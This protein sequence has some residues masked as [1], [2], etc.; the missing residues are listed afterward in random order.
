MSTRLINSDS[1][2][3]VDTQLQNMQDQVTE[4]VYSDAG[5]HDF[6]GE[7]GATITAA[8]TRLSIENIVTIQALNNLPNT[9]IINNYT[10]IS[11]GI[12][13]F[14][15]FPTNIV[16]KDYDYLTDSSILAEDQQLILADSTNSAFTIILPTGA[17]IGTTVSVLDYSSMFNINSVTITTNHLQKIQNSFDNFILDLPNLYNF[18]Y[19][20]EQFGWILTNDNTESTLIYVSHYYTVQNQDKVLVDTTPNSFTIFLNANPEQ[21]DRF[22]IIDVGGQFNN[23]S[24]IIDANGQTIF[25]DRSTVLDINDISIS[26]IFNTKW[27]YVEDLPTI[28]SAIKSIFENY[29][30]TNNDYLFINDSLILTLPANPN[31]G[32]RI[33]LV[34][35]CNFEINPLTINSNGSMINGNR[36][37]LIADIKYSSI[38]LVFINPTKG[39]LIKG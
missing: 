14:P 9:N 10:D 11:N 39:W 1:I 27:I 35:N 30:C 2:L 23:K 4:V 31:I 32:D 21:Y 3:G 37:N 36:A 22:T 33:V 15:K 18:I 24:L 13:I 12:D 19:I 7:S 29:I 16:S 5:M 25:D 38:T 26:F 6:L 34:D 8:L 20:G 17:K 28:D